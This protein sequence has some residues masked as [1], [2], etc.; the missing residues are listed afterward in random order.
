MSESVPLLQFV[1]NL[2]DMEFAS[3]GRPGSV[4]VAGHSQ[5]AALALYASVTYSRRSWDDGIASFH[6]TESKVVDPRVPLCEHHAC[7]LQIVRFV[8]GMLF[9]VSAVSKLPL[10]KHSRQR[11]QKGEVSFI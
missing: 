8:A 5:G 7:K 1:H 6:Y 11:E 3:G 4:V 10:S 2:L 9:P